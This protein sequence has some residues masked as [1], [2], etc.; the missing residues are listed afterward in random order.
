MT[1]D[2]E[3]VQE[4]RKI[5]TTKTAENITLEITRLIN[6]PRE[7]VFEAWT[8]PEQLRKWFGP[9]DDIVVMQAKVDLRAGGKYRIQMKK[10][11]GEFHTAAGTYREVKPPERLVFTWA[12][13]KDG[14]EPD[15]G[16]VE[17][18]EMLITLEFQPRGEQT[19]FVLTQ[20]QFASVE[21][22]DRHEQGWTGCFDKLEKFFGK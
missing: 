9:D 3:T 4:E 22:R 20:E 7:R 21:S 5:M 15:F 2:E 14:G 11:D 1:D 16:E 18:T 8:N 6:A 12:W 10:P 17:P 13:E 19:E